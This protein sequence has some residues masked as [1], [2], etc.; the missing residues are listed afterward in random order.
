MARTNPYANPGNALQLDGVQGNK[1]AI[2]GTLAITCRS[3]QIEV[4]PSGVP[5]TAKITVNVE[6][7]AG[8]DVGLAVNP[9]SEIA[10]TASYPATFATKG[11]YTIKVQVHDGNKK[12]SFQLVTQDDPSSFT[13]TV[14]I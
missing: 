7:G 9:A 4:T 14:N 10:Q 8:H 11:P 2:G 6:D 1:S 3:N 13:Q 5:A 12:N